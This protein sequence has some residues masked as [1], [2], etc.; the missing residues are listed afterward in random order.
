MII[1]DMAGLSDCTTFMVD[2]TGITGIQVNPEFLIIYSA[3][4]VE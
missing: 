2:K 4:S 1:G 3:H